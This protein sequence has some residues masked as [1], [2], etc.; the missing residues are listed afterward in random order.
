MGMVINQDVLLGL[1][2]YIEVGGKLKFL[3]LGNSP[4]GVK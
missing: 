1:A 2:I 4:R 3:T